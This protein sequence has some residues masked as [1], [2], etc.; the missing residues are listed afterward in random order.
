MH[1][2][3]LLNIHIYVN[4]NPKLHYFSLLLWVVFF[5]ITIFYLKHLSVCTCKM[6][7]HQALVQH[8]NN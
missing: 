4:K 2:Y 3:N 8:N 6:C 1:A 5:N 7:I